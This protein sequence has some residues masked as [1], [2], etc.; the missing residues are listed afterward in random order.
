[1]RTATEISERSVGV[2]RDGLERVAG[3]LVADQVV[4]QLDLVV[5]LFCGE[6]LAGLRHG[7][8]GALEGL[9]GAHVLAHAGFDRRE[10]LLRNH[11]PVGEL[12]VVVEAVLDRRSNRD[13]H[14]WVELED[15]L[16]QHMGGVVADQGEGLLAI[17]L[18][19]N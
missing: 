13:L 1:M 4:D 10:V 12:E 11:D 3:I 5:L 18:G 2:Q 8:I 16:G 9:A 14:S 7:Q 19:H 17:A 15:G 6:P